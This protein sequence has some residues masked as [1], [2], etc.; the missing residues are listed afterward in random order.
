MMI[1][2]GDTVTARGECRKY[3][4]FAATRT[5][6]SAIGDVWAADDILLP[7]KMMGSAVFVSDLPFSLAFDVLFDAPVKFLHGNPRCPWHQV[8]EF[9]W[10]DGV[11]R[12][13]MTETQVRSALE[14]MGGHTLKVMPRGVW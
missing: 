13:G 9:R 14:G 8:E 10:L 6:A 4:Y 3:G 2:M 12:T 5:D 1:V 11:I 7:G